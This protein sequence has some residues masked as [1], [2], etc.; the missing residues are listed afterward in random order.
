MQQRK[1]NGRFGSSAG[2]HV[3]RISDPESPYDFLVF[4]RAGTLVAPINLWGRLRRGR[5]SMKT[6]EAYLDMLLPW[7]GWLQDH[8][9]PWN[10]EPDAVRQGTLEYLVQRGC[11]LRL[12]LAESRRAAEAKPSGYIVKLQNGSPF[13]TSTLSLFIQAT[14]DFYTVLTEG[15]WRKDQGERV[16]Y[17]PYSNPMY[18]EALVR[19]KREHV[20]AL[21]SAGAPDRAGIRG[22]SH[23]ETRSHPTGW[24][25]PVRNAWDPPVASDAVTVRAV[26]A[27]AIMWMIDHAPLRERVIMKILLESGCRLHEVLG[28]AA[29]GYRKGRAVAV[30][31]PMGAGAKVVNK[32]RLG[33]EVKHIYFLVST[34]DLLREYV[35]TERS[36]IDPSSRTQVDEL[37][38]DESIFLSRH[39]RSLSDGAFRAKWRELLTALQAYCGDKQLPVPLPELHPHLI[40]H[41][42]ATLRFLAARQRHTGDPEALKAAEEAI[43]DMMMWASPE[44]AKRYNHSLS[45]IEN[46]ELNH[47]DFVDAITSQAHDLSGLESLFSTQRQDESEP[48]LSAGGAEQGLPVIDDEYLEEELKWV[49]AQKRGIE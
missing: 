32:G 7:F 18:A 11:I 27:M 31:S 26:I 37:A 35:A 28:L 36:R 38:D 14:R 1:P 10:G 4:D 16:S 22:E 2:F 20:S 43:Q 46:I 41:L 5:G 8:G 24:F 23:A 42:H 44:T 48:W 39:G 30:G 34:D 25:R 17:Y 29:G 33:Q 21:A 9:Y 12:P 49:Q 6:R 47:W 13:S 19:M 15:E 3:L 40:R 45:K